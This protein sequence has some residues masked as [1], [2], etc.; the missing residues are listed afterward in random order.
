MQITVNIPDEL[1]DEARSRGLAVETYVEQVL[2]QQFATETPAGPLR[3]AKEIEN[4]LESLAQYSEKIPALP[5]VISRD[6][7]YQDHD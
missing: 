2:Q 7:I 3:S 6:W 5:K 1:A 4:W